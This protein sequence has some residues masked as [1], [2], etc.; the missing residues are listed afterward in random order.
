MDKYARWLLIF[1]VVFVATWVV[2]AL[3]T[4]LI[5]NQIAWVSVFVILAV[6][7]L[8]DTVLPKASI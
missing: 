5:P 1:V 4:N 2:T 7:G 8:M 6:Y 3:A